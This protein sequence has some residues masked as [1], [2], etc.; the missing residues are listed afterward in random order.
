MWREQVSVAANHP[1][2]NS[3][4]DMVL[5]AAALALLTLFVYLML[6]LLGVVAKT[7]GQLS[8]EYSLTKA[9]TP[10]P[11]WLA[12]WGRNF[13]NLCEMP[14]LFYALVG[15]MAISATAIDALQVT[16]AWAFVGSR[17]V[18]TLIHVTVNSLGLRFLAHRIG[19][20]ILAVMWVRFTMDLLAAQA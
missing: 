15:L 8:E 4:S 2:E 13:A 18:H 16:L 12:N 17:Y 5:A 20:I 3:M 6:T 11:D 19:F 9:G 1:G 10:P 14:I 7:R